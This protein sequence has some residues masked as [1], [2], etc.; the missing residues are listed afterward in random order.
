MQKEFETQVLDIDAEQIKNKLRGLGAEETPEFSQKRWVFD[1]KCLEDEGIGEWVRLR[2]VNG[3][4]TIT[5]KNRKGLGISDTEEIEVE[6]GDF[7]KAAEILS[8]L[9]CWSGN[10]YQE[11]K[12]TRF[13]FN[14]IEFT[15]D[16]WPR[17][18]AFLEIEAKSEKKVK[19]GLKLLGLEGKD[20]GH[21]GLIKI[22][23][24]YG[25]R[26]HDYKEIKF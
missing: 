9:K 23:S 19:E 24:R 14:D 1:I 21:L 18:P 6:A 16:R 25:I 5:Y 10:Y 15:I 12:R 7:D 2:E 4:A 11:N 26:L 20:A 13:L 17:I 22:Y 8:K 3:K